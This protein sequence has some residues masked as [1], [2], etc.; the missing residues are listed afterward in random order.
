MVLDLPAWQGEFCK[1]KDISLPVVDFGFIHC[2]STYDAISTRNGKLVC[3]DMHLDRFFRGA[4]LLRIKVPLTRQEI[5]S[6]INELLDRSPIPDPLVFIVI[7]RGMAEN[8][9]RDL[10]TPKP[11]F[12]MFLRPCKPWP[13][14][15][16]VSVCVSTVMRNDSIDQTIKNFSWNDLT[17]AQWEAIDRGYDTAIL[18][19]RDWFITEG[20]AFNFGIIKNDRVYAPAKVRLGGITMERVRLLCEQ[21]LIPFEFKDITV[22]EA[23]NSDAA[24]LTST[25]A[26]V[27]TVRK[28]EEIEYK[29]NFIL[30]ILRRE[31]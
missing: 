25:G 5:V 13:N 18:L 9:A 16:T 31:V 4:D 12:F 28:L 22:K 29:Q 27:V 15:N 23:K 8:G 3:L 10:I 26:H 30:D 11:N 20:P 21:Y 1:V 6:K 14:D 19:S 2:D 24:F 17:M 7:T